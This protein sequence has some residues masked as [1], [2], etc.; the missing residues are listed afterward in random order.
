[1]NQIVLVL[2]AIKLESSLRDS[3]LNRKSLQK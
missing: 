1:M 2:E 3:K